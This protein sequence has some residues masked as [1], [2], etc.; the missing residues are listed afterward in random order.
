ML[1][2]I[3]VLAAT[4]AA[5]LGASTLAGAA[6]SSSTPTSSHSRNPN[7]VTVVAV[8]GRR[9]NVP[10]R[11]FMRAYANCPKGY[12]VTGGGAYNGAITEVVSGPQ[13]NMRGWYVDGTNT[14][15]NKRTFAH[16]A[17]AVCVKGSKSV[18]VASA[19]S[20]SAA[21][22]EAEAAFAASHWGTTGH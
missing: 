16:W 5:V 17:D 10:Y 12:F 6:G 22:H 9:V 1:K 20:S 13:P 14:D 21:I 7:A 8:L 15:P 11:K 2:F 18:P 3:T 4:V 19:A